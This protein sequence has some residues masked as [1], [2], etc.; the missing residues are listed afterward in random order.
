MSDRNINGLQL[1]DIAFRRFRK[2][3]LKW[4]RKEDSENCSIEKPHPDDKNAVYM[5]FTCLLGPAGVAYVT[6]SPDLPA[7]VEGI[8]TMP[9]DDF[10]DCFEPVIRSS[11]SDNG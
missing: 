10:L 6:Y 7:F 4:R 5:V 11:R 9:V 2:I 8:Y 1:I 3:S